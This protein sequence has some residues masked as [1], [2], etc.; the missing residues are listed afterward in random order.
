MQEVETYIGNSIQCNPIVWLVR[1]LLLPL[2]RVS[3]QTAFP[4]CLHARRMEKAKQMDTRATEG[5][6]AR[7]ML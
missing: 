7:F 5:D 6:N 3:L 1:R 2:A 4:L